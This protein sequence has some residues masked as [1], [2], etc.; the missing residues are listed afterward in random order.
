MLHAATPVHSPFIQNLLRE[1]AEDGSF[2]AGIADGSADAG[3]FFANLDLALRTG[4]LRTLG[5]DG[6]LS[7]Q[8]HVAGYVYAPREDESPVGFGLF[9]DLGAHGFELWL[10]GIAR[11]ARGHGHG[12]VMLRELIATPPGQLATLVRCSRNN[13]SCDVA[14]KLFAELGF[15]PGRTTSSLVWLV[16]AKAPPDLAERI[17]SLPAAA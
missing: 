8:A 17:A 15:L 2:E 14:M 1:G 11:G 6:T 10:T 4:F 7:S 5:A 13:P 9:K 12:R 16:S 3:L